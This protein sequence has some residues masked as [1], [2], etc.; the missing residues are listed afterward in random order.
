MASGSAVTKVLIDPPI[1]QK[2]KTL[3]TIA[4]QKQ[5]SFHDFNKDII[6]DVNQNSAALSS[7]KETLQL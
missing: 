3:K 5:T 6:N 7:Q 1:I 4:G 2:G